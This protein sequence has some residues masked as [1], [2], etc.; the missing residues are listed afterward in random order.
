MPKITKDEVEAR[1][2]PKTAVGLNGKLP[3]PRGI[4]LLMT[5]YGETKTGKTRLFGTF[6]KP[7][8]IIGSED[9]SRS[10]ALPT[11]R[12]RKTLEQGRRKLAIFA[13]QTIG[14]ETGKPKDTGV[15]LC[16]PRESDWIDGPILD[17]VRQHYVSVAFDNG[18]GIQDI[19]LKEVLGITDI[20]VQRNY[21]MADQ[22]QWGMVAMQFK[23]RVDKYVQ[24]ARNHGL[25]VMIIAHDKNFNDTAKAADVLLPSIG[26]A[27]T[28]SCA[29]WINGVCDYITNTFIREQVQVTNDN[30]VEIAMKTGKFEY[31]LRVGTHNI[32]Q[33]GF[34]CLPGVE[35][36]SVIVNP[37]YDK[38]VKVIQGIKV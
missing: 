36:P 28:K 3:D 37:T 7:A 34:R 22:G 1:P 31:C 25:N 24:L 14:K 18:G 27:L 2:E 16:L 20:P 26:P 33:V 19:I 4:G 35:P 38:I 29:K 12:V 32:Y 17:E 10:I 5:T 9:G 11:K 15:D 13:L 21:G 6:P 8:L 23:E 30:G